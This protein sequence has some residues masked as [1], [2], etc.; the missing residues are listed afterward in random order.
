MKG[1]LLPFMKQAT[2]A[3][4]VISAK[5]ISKTFF[6]S[7]ITLSIIVKVLF[8]PYL[9]YNYTPFYEKCQQEKLANTGTFIKLFISLH[10]NFINQ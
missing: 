4:P 7:I 9:Q 2:S 8:R 3:A 5:V 1:R 10:N 6:M